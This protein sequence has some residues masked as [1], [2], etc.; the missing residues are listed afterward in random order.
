MKHFCEVFFLALALIL[1]VYGQT[2]L[3]IFAGAF[4]IIAWF[5]PMNATG[6]SV[7]QIIAEAEGKAGQTIYVE[8]EFVANKGEVFTANLPHYST[9][10]LVEEEVQIELAEYVSEHTGIPIEADRLHVLKFNLEEV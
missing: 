7:E 2:G 10:T 4:C 3:A 8:Y 5:W 9:D 1:A 6:K